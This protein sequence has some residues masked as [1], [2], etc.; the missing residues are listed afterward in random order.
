M[1]GTGVPLCQ[2]SQTAFLGSGPERDSRAAAPNRFQTFRVYPNGRFWGGFG[3]LEA[4]GGP[5]SE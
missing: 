1:R 4:A 5:P 3:S 2:P